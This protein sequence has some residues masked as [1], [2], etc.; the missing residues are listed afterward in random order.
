MNKKQKITLLSGVVFML[1]AF[2]DWAVQGF[3]LFTHERIL[4]Q[5]PQSDINKMLGQPPRYNWVNHFALGLDYTLSAAA[6]IIIISAIL[7][8]LF[9]TRKAI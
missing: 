2:A 9:K 8:F 3:H 1:F 6:V 5:I 7:F 4:V